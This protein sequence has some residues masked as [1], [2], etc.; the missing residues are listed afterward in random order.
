MCS[1][2]A[3]SVPE[4]PVP[5]PPV[6]EPPVELVPP[7]EAAPPLEAPPVVLAPPVPAS[8]P[9]VAATWPPLLASA[10]LP[11]SDEPQPGRRAT[12]VPST[13]KEVRIVASYRHGYEAASAFSL[14]AAVQRCVA[15]D[16]GSGRA[17]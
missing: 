8:V 6:L 1:A 17:G 5:S 12:K 3:A 15:L 14:S 11:S 4:P 9:P 16:R 7:V 13:H 2:T 10:L